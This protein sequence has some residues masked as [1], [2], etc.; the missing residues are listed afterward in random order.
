[1][2]YDGKK[3]RCPKNCSRTVNASIYPPP[4]P[5]Q[6]HI[7]QIGKLVATNTHTI[8]VYTTNYL[9]AIVLKVLRGFLF[10]I[11][12]HLSIAPCTFKML[13]KKRKKNK[14]VGL[15][16]SSRNFFFSQTLTNHSTMITQIIFEWPSNSF[17]FSAQFGLIL[18]VFQFG[19]FGYSGTLNVLAYQLE[20]IP[21]W[22]FLTLFFVP[23]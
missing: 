19:P 22:H 12:I 9:T 23:L 4:P 1:M 13:N 8:T 14:F 16:I 15:I 17:L 5:F 18:F 21:W 6:H 2:R 7:K 3:R 11:P 10:S 20:N